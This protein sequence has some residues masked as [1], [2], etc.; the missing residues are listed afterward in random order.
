[1]EKAM[2][3]K[4]ISGVRIPDSALALKVTQLIRDTEGDLLFHHSARVYCWGVLT[5]DRMGLKFDPE[6][7]YA[8]SMFHDIGLTARYENSQLRFEVDGANVAR[9][10]LRG[11]SIS[12]NDIEK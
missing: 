11:H 10:F 9:D 3:L 8:A 7:L 6:L 4:D 5:G 2:M 1:M 12:E